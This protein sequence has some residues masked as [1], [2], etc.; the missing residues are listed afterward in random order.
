MSCCWAG[1][2]AAPDPCPWGHMPGIVG[3]CV[4]QPSLMLPT[5]SMDDDY[6][7]ELLQETALWFAPAIMLW[8]EGS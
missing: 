7:E 1:A 6:P 8:R 2:V 5:L 4:A 3:W